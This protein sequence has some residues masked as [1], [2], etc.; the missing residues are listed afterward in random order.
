MRRLRS[1]AGRHWILAA[2]VALAVLMLLS[3][4]SHTLDAIA[5][6]RQHLAPQMFAL[7]LTG[8]IAGIVLPPLA[9]LVLWRVARG[10][11][12]GCLVDL[13]LL[14]ALWG[15]EWATGSMILHAVDEPDMDGPSGWVTI[16]ATFLTMI[17]LAT[18]VTAL[19]SVAARASVTREESV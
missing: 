17:V 10:R 9:A 13:M 16:P 18:Y 5:M 14:P 8:L 1:I 7:W 15:I 2:G 3:T 11:R 4:G 6:Y 19:F 12:L